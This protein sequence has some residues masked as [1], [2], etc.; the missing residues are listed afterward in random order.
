MLDI[1]YQHRLHEISVPHLNPCSGDLKFNFCSVSA[2]HKSLLHP[3]S[4]DH[5]SHTCCHNLRNRK[6]MCSICHSVEKHLY[7]TNMVLHRTQTFSTIHQIRTEN[8]SQNILGIPLIDKR[9]QNIGEER[10]DRWQKYR[11][12]FTIG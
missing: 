2:K 5:W 1:Y 7:T 9:V 11:C 3:E 6:T 4:H 8:E 12:L 10:T